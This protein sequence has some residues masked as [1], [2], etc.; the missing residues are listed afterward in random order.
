MRAQLYKSIEVA[1]VDSF[2][3]RE[4]DYIILS[5]VRSN[6]H[7]GIGFLSDPR[8]LNV[9]L[10]RS[11]YG[12]IILGNARLLAKNPLWNALINHYRDN[13]VVAEG[14]L[15][16]LQQTMMSFPPPR[17]R[18]TEKHMY[19]SPLANISQGQLA[20]AY[21]QQAYGVG[22]GYHGQGRRDGR[23]VSRNG[24]FPEQMDDSRFDPRY[25]TA[26]ATVSSNNGGGVAAA[27]RGY[28]A[29]YGYSSGFTYEGSQRPLSQAS[30]S[31]HA[32]AYGAGSSYGVAS[33]TLSFSQVSDRLVYGGAGMSQDRYSAYEDVYKGM[34]FFDSQGPNT[35]ATLSQGNVGL[36]QDSNVVA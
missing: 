31:Q 28:G 29:G 26:Q 36:S 1:S 7:Q 9:A 27:G 15:N 32:S 22:G 5:C 18:A 3:G 25:D 13:N 24:R 10:T 19:M 16:N 8:R 6:E 4:K 2:Q 35:Q 20:T 11:R 23:G 30:M 14:P 34:Q 17:V 21:A 12:V 33:Q